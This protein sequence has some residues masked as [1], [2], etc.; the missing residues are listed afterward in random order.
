MKEAGE[1]LKKKFKSGGEEKNRKRERLK[2][3]AFMFTMRPNMRRDNLVNMEPCVW[4]KQI[5]G[6][7]TA[8]KAYEMRGYPE[9]FEIK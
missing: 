5:I 8:V 9:T 7:M 3:K 2:N 6:D 4:D 1:N